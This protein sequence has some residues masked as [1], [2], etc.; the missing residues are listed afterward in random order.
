MSLHENVED[1]DRL[2]AGTIIDGR[3]RIRRVLGQGGF[4]VVYEVDHLRLD[5]L[6]ALKVLDLHGSSRDMATFRERFEREAKLA[7]RIEHA[8][9]VKIYDYGF[10]EQN[11]QPYIAMELLRGHDLEHELVNHGALAPE[12]ARHLFLGALEALQ[13]AHEQS[14][15]HKDLKPSNLFLVDVGTARERLVV[16]DYGIA[17]VFDD[18]SSRLTQTDQFAGTPAYIAPEYIERHEVSPAFDVYQMGLI[19]LESLLGEP[20]I[21]ADSTLGYLVAHCEGRH[22][23]DERF[24]LTPL[25]QAL[26]RAIATDPK[27]RFSDAGELARALSAV[28]WAVERSGVLSRPQPRDLPTRPEDRIANQPTLREPP[29]PSL[30]HATGAQ[31]LAEPWAAPPAPAAESSRAPLLLVLAGVGVACMLA[32]GG[33]ALA[34]MMRSEK[35]SD[36]PTPPPLSSKTPTMDLNPP[37]ISGK[38]QDSQKLLW[39]LLGM[40]FTYGPVMQMVTLHKSYVKAYG[41]DKPEMIVATAFYG[42]PDNFKHGRMH[43]SNACKAKPAMAPID[44]ACDAYLKQLKE[45]GLVF[46][47]YEVYYRTERGYERDSMARGKALYERFERVWAEYKPASE[48]MW[49]GLQVSVTRYLH[50][51]KEALKADERLVQDPLLGALLEL[52]PMVEALGGDPL[53]KMASGRVDALEAQMRALRQAL[54]TSDELAPAAHAYVG[55]DTY[56]NRL[57][58]LLKSA[59]DTQRVAKS[60]QDEPELSQKSERA[61]AMSAVYLNYFQLMMLYMEH[62]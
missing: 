44:Q 54:R 8:N 48:A 58:D 45:L 35:V 16:L 47:D 23:I 42:M 28:S 4:A 53:S 43:A 31:G 10:V 22:E 41:W 3:Y 9:V 33:I 55:P 1:D 62:H 26:Q 27:V 21:K 15:V 7:A 37:V 50:T 60:T 38:S 30:A 59:R 11:Q 12:R 51:K 34:L 29:Q 32:L 25:G 13:V 19:I 14:V 2:A 56:L 24:A 5:R 52:G 46:E 49:A 40:Q 61:S 17:R 39:A 36:A 18:D 57:D 6:A 20:A